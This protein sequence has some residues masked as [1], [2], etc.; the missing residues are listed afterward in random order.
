VAAAGGV[1]GINYGAK[2]HSASAIFMTVQLGCFVLW[3]LKFRAPY[4]K[5]PPPS[6]EEV[7]RVERW[8][9]DF[10]LLA[11]WLIH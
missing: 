10:I 3:S 9:E 4:V 8:N 2:S 7:A 1:F 6:P 11:K 5:A